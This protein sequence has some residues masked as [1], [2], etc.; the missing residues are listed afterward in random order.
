MAQSV[1]HSN[2]L[3]AEVCLSWFLPHVFINS[4]LDNPHCSQIVL[5]H[6]SKTLSLLRHRRYVYIDYKAKTHCQISRIAVLWCLSEIPILHLPVWKH[7]WPIVAPPY[8]N[9]K[10]KEFLSQ[11]PGY[12]QFCS[13]YKSVV[14]NQTT[15]YER[16]WH[17]SHFNVC[18]EV[19][20][21][22]CTF[23]LIAEFKSN[24]QYNFFLWFMAEL[25]TEFQAPVIEIWYRL[26]AHGC[27]LICPS[28]LWSRSSL[29]SSEQLAMSLKKS[30]TYWICVRLL[31]E[32]YYNF[33]Y[34]VP[35]Y[36]YGWQAGFLMQN[37][38]HIFLLEVANSDMP[39]NR[40]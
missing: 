40:I 26:S 18:L 2:T 25:C 29:H 5:I 11:G 35:S 23:S 3:V 38:F 13:F 4:T 14:K 1:H 37:G 10:I 28:N 34:G 36:K 39:V 24:F 31:S 33:L 22:R 20:H 30:S 19:F 6:N 16:Q 12:S 21:L 9:Q 32:P 15:K 8:L 27:L 7:S 17:K